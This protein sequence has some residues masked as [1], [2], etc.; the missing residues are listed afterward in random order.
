MRDRDTGSAAVALDGRLIGIL[1][2]RD[3]L[4]AFAA[5][6]QPAQARV[7]EWMTSE[8]VAVSA[9]TRVEVAVSLMTEHGVHQLPVVDGKRPVGMLG[10]RQAASQAWGRGIG[11]GF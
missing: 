5:R 9:S 6:V 2:S 11:L 3:L 7:R 8:P 1:T 10:Y 4:R